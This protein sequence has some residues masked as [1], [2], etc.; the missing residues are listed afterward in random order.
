MPMCEGRPER[1]AALMAA[2]RPATSDKRLRPAASAG[3]PAAKP[4]GIP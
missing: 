4:A 3:L 1:I 2:D